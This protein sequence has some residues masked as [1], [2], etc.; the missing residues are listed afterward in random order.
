MCLVEGKSQHA[1]TGALSVAIVPV[2]PN[3]LACRKCTATGALAAGFVLVEAL[4]KT[5]AGQQELLLVC[6]CAECVDFANFARTLGSDIEDNKEGVSRVL[7]FLR[8]VVC[9]IFYGLC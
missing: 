6:S 5:M 8:A 2:A 7:V 4:P 1:D 3:T 9:A